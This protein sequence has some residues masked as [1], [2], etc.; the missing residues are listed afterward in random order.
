LD[1]TIIHRIQTHGKL[2]HTQYLEEEE[3]EDDPR[4]GGRRRKDAT[5]GIAAGGIAVMEYQKGS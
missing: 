2:E 4:M 5:L 1:F 3:E